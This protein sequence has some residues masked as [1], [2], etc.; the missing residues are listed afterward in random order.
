MASLANAMADRRRAGAPAT[1]R[2]IQLARHPTGALSPDDFRLVVVPV[3]APGPGV[4]LVRNTWTSV[5]AGL[6]LRTVP[7]GPRGYFAAFAL[8]APLD[9]IMTVGIVVE[10][11]ADAFAPGDVVSHALGWREYSV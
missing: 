1:G 10:S 6:R 3:R 9:G 2:E 8:G 7:A 4:V 5:D 11:H